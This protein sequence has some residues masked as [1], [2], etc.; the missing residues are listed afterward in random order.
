M[1]P[2]RDITFGFSDAENYRRRDQKNLFNRIFLRTDALDGICSSSTFFLVGEKGTGKTAYAVY[3]SASPYRNIVSTHKFIR[4]TD[5]QK[6]ISLKR[7]NSLSLSEYTDIW[8]VVIYVLIAD[9]IWTSYENSGVIFKSKAFLNLKSAL[10]EYYKGAFSPEIP[11]AI[12]IVENIDDVVKLLVKNDLVEIGA[13]SNSSKGVTRSRQKFQTDLLSIQRAFESAFS[14]LKLDATHLLFVDGVD[15]RPPSIPYNEYLDCVKG[16]ANAIWSV[17]NDVFPRLRDSPGRLRSVLLLR[18]DIFN[19]LSLQNRNTKLRDNSV[20]LNWNTWYKTHR[21]S[22]LF[23]MADRMFGAQQ[24]A[25]PTVGDSWDYYFPFDATNVKTDSGKYSSFILFLRY[26]FHRPRD[27]LSML[28]ILRE[29]LPD[30]SDRV[31]TYEDLTTPDFRRAYGDYLLGEIRD[32]LSFYYDEFE[33]ENFFKFFEYLDGSH[34]FDYDK[35]LDAFER[36]ST[37]LSAQGRS[38][39]SFMRTAEEFLQFLYDQNILSFKEAAGDE[40]FIRWCFLERTVSNISPKVKT[41]VDYEIHYGLANALNTGKA[42]QRRAKKIEESAGEVRSVGIVDRYIAKGKFGFIR[43]EGLPVD[44]YFS[45][46]DV[47]GGGKVR[48]GQ[49]V[50]YTLDKDRLGR[51][52]AK[53][54]EVKD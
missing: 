28:D 47:A 36:F 11:T 52:V 19:S 46:R 33:I 16:L 4:E 43:Q 41:D 30:D 27:I 35:Y 12:Q 44:V 49:S 13:E 34:R 10:D 51:L 32:S 23:L 17:N 24:E 38:H 39:P 1:K 37:Y 50:R 22:D 7:Q 9:S 15:I 29:K 31:F 6:F 20:V 25:M 21:T 2:I 42:L 40:T 53:R 5:Y 18:P 26:S 54:I 3:L 8:R 45:H 14:S 48:R